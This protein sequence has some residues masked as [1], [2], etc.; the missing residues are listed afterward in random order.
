MAA[1]GA[2]KLVPAVADCD[3]PEVTMIEGGAPATLV[4][5]NEAGVETPVTDAVTAYDP[6]APFP[7]NT[8]AVAMPVPLVTAVA[9]VTEPAKVP[10]GPLD[11]AVN[12][13]VIPLSGL[14]DESFTNAVNGAHGA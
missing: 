13:T 6:A 1:S 11:G 9:V 2:A 10:L 14:P 12:V 7:V 5:A 8:G 3:A 4:K